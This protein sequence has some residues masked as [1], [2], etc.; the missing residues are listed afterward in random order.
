MSKFVARIS[1]EIYGPC[2][3]ADECMTISS[4][5]A[6]EADINPNE[7]NECNICPEGYIVDLDTNI[8]KKCTRKINEFD[9]LDCVS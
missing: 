9:R 8:C 3:S 6:V 7:I 5:P 4:L 2:V 1:G